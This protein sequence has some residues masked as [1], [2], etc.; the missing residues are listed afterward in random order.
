MKLAKAYT[1]T[2]I[3][4]IIKHLGSYAI[5]GCGRS[6]FIILIDLFGKQVLNKFVIGCFDGSNQI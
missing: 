2:N 4:R 3:V 5:P 1:L 6:F